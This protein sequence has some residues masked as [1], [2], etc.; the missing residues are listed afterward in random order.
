MAP[1]DL[2]PALL[3]LLEDRYPGLFSALLNSGVEPTAPATLRERLVTKAT[4]LSPGLTTDLP[5]T[6]IEDMASTAVGALMQI[7]QAKIDLINAI[8]PLNATASMLDHFG[9]IYGVKRGASANPSAYVTFNGTPGLFLGKGFQVSDGT[10]LYETQSN[11]TLPDTGVLPNVYV[12]ATTTGDY[13][14]PAGTITQIVSGLSASV[15]LSVTNPQPGTTGT[16]GETNAAYRA[17]LLQAGQATSQGTP[18]FI[19]T[20][21]QKV[22]NIIPRSISV[23]ITRDTHD[24]PQSYAVTA[25]GGDPQQVAGAIYESCF[26]LLSLRGSTNT[27]SSASND[28]PCTLT[29]SLAHGLT[30]GQSVT[31]S[32]AQG[33]TRLNGTFPATVLDSYRFTLPLDTRQDPLYQ[34]GAVIHTNPRNITATILDGTDRYT[35]PFIRPLQQKVRLIAHWQTS[36]VNIIDNDTAT[37]LCAP[38][39]ADYINSLSVNEPLNTLQLGTVFEAAVLQLVPGNLI[40]E[41]SFEIYLD[42]ILTTPP[43]HSTVIAGDPE[44][45]FVITPSDISLVRQ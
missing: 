17:R 1:N 33:M 16:D 18:N 44:S 10:Y 12:L 14:I 6:L 31:I 39:I 24:T 35:I 5:G 36:A 27:I 32:G 26:D 23:A 3:T 28:D 4:E 30:N 22:P 38:K 25:D 7:D 8:S 15:S 40:T 29:T 34:G 20:C 41:L 11:L 43:A 37:Q 45:Y 19:K 9:E 21:L 2:S 13:H 42:D